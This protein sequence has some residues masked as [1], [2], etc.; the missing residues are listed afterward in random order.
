MSILT[1]KFKVSKNKIFQ[2]THIYTQNEES[3]NNILNFGHILKSK[4]SEF[5][6]MKAS[7]KDFSSNIFFLQNSIL[8]S[9]CLVFHY[10]SLILHVHC[11]YTRPLYCVCACHT[12]FKTLSRK[13]S[14]HK[15]SRSTD[16][17]I[18]TT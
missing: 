16:D 13:I 12:L 11:T 9:V 6:S 3:I 7:L 8:T 18:N 1:V 2:E 15:N 14:I 4:Y 17:I 5:N 10:K